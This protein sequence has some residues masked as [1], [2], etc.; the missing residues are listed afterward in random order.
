M[1]FFRRQIT[2]NYPLGMAIIAMLLLCFI[3]GVNIYRR[4]TTP[5]DGLQF[6]VFAE[7]HYE[8]YQREINGPISKNIG[9]VNLQLVQSSAMT[10]Q[11]QLDISNSFSGKDVPD[12]VEIDIGQVGVFFRPP[13]SDI[14]FEPLGPYLEKSGR[15]KDIIP[16][17]L[18]T[19]TRRSEIFGV[20]NDVHPVG[21]VYREDLFRQAGID[22]S[23]AATW[24]DFQEKCLQFQEYWKSKGYNDRHAIEMYSSRVDHLLVMLQQRSINL[25]DDQNELHLDKNM[26]AQTLAFYAQCVAGKRSIASESGP[27]DAAINR[28]LNDGNICCYFTPDWRIASIRQAGTPF[29]KGKFRFMPLPRF[30]PTDAPTASWGGTMIGILRTSRNKEKAWKLIEKLYLEKDSVNKRREI[31]GILPPIPSFWDDPS[32]QKPDP[33][34]GGQQL[35]QMLVSLARQLPVRT[36]SPATNIINYYMIQVLSQATLVAEKQAQV[37]SIEQYRKLLH[38]ASVDL[39]KRIT[40]MDFTVPLKS[41]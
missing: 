21:L 4:Q 35:D 10:R 13:N 36:V 14:G 24:P 22:L 30:D 11:L 23:T 32:Y 33:F 5:P 18:A 15:L 1:Q 12:V 27:G 7:R 8:A 29:L 37:D 26:T 41:G 38:E 28:D 3:A 17:R 19:W 40:Q 20:P 9:P 2:F 6:W 39:Q 16:S 34:F 25:I 31:T